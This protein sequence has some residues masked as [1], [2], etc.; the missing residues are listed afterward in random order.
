MKKLFI[1][2]FAI[3]CLMTTAIVTEAATPSNQIAVVVVG[4]ADY[5]TKDF[6]KT[7]KSLFKVSDNLELAVGKEVQTKYQ[8]YWLDKGLIDEGTPTKEDFVQF[9]NYSGYRKVVYL[10]IKDSVVDQHGRKKGKD[11]SRISLTVNA[12]LVD[13][14]KVDQVDSS[15]NEEDSKTSELRAR[16]GA[17][18][19]CV[20]DISET[21]NPLH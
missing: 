12:F 3:V 5:K 20:K 14:M 7:T 18:K 1:A 16:L 19:Q 4:G 9:V 17:F 8:K 21:F 6:I 2:L 13:K 10:V 15:T 11:R